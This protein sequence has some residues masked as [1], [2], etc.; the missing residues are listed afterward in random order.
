MKLCLTGL[1][2]GSAALGQSTLYYKATILSW[3]RYQ[4][5][6]NEL[7]HRWELLITQL[8]APS[9]DTGV[10]WCD[11]CT[12]HH[13][14]II[15]CQVTKCRAIGRAIWRRFF[16]SVFVSDLRKKASVTKMLVSAPS[17]SVTSGMSGTFS[18][19]DHPCS[20]EG[21][22]KTVKFSSCHNLSTLHNTSF[23]QHQKSVRL[24]WNNFA[25]RGTLFVMPTSTRG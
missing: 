14:T 21:R 6:D 5:R 1:G 10:P 11:H 12:D 23:V 19:S 16:C 9:Q 15:K 22:K 24:H 25:D 7:R 20:R 17:L 13:L 8:P 4:S 2:L 3:H 18:T